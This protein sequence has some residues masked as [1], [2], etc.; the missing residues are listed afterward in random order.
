[1]IDDA[2]FDDLMELVVRTFLSLS[3]EVELEGA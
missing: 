1:M 3:L 2:G